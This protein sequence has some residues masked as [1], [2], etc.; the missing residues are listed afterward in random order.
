ML[1]YEDTTVKD[2]TMNQVIGI[3]ADTIKEL[4]V[5]GMTIP[6]EDEGAIPSHSTIKTM[7]F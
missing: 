5:E 3:W 4:N 1:T 2:G 7:K 6:G